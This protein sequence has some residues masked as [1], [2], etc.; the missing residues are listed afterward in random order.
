MALRIGDEVSLADGTWC[1]VVGVSE[2]GE[3]L[4]QDPW[5]NVLETSDPVERESEVGR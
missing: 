3:A 2:I 5:G 1:T 4:L